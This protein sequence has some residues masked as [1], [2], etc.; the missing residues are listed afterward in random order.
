MEVS[1]QGQRR[2]WLW[3][4]C[5]VLVA[6]AVRGGTASPATAWNESDVR[7]SDPAHGFPGA[8]KGIREPTIAIHPV[9]PDMMIAAAIDMTTLN[10]DPSQYGTIRVFRSIDGGDTWLDQGPLVYRSD[11]TEVAYSG[12]PVAAFGPDGTAYL[13][14]LADFPGAN[15]AREGG[16]YVHRS[17]DAGATWGA[18]VLAV[19]NRNDP[20]ANTC[21]GT[22]KEWLTVDPLSGRLYLAYTLFTSDMC[23]SYGDPLDLSAYAGISDIAVYLTTSGDRGATWTEPRKV[24]SGYALGATPLTA[25][26]GSVSVAFWAS[27]LEPSVPC[28]TVVGAVP[29]RAGGS[30]FAALVVARSIDGGG[31]WTYHKEGTCGAEPALLMPGSFVGGTIVPTG[32]VDRSTGIAYV[33]WPAYSVVD[34]RFSVKVIASRNGGRTWSRPAV[35][36]HRSD[37]ALIPAIDATDGVARLVYVT[38]QRDPA[39]QIV[40]RTRATGDTFVVESRD[41]GLSW[42][43]PVR[44]STVSSDYSLNADVS[45]YIGID[46][47]AG[48]V[49]A[50][51]T[52][53][54]DP[55][56][57]QIWARVGSAGPAAN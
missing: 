39:A 36:S 6:G 4:A 47:A 17:A 46:V 5:L 40:G 45:D 1:R 25:P 28:P 56:D 42:S 53:A 24:W 21:S 11:P 14:S 52:D 30:P 34:Q 33:A 23:S 19:A 55:S 32:T 54:R 9:E 41:G 37:H 3:L 26:D 16:I 12:D 27:S 10:R 7:V 20:A 8:F 48:R 43:L 18:P 29:I 13:A 57:P 49:A 50:I 15:D 38:A 51:W 44:I 22:D 2:F 35:L 31:T